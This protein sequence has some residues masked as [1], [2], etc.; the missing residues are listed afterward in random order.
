MSEVRNPGA[1]VESLRVL[2]S[3][4]PHRRRRL[5]TLLIGVTA[6]IGA[7][8][9]PSAQALD[10][11]QVQAEEGIAPGVMYRT[12]TGPGPLAA[13]TATVDPSA[14]VRFATVLSGARV[15]GGLEPVSA[16]CRRAG[17]VAC[18]N[19]NFPVCPKCQQPFG[20]VVRDR[21]IS[22][23]P[24]D[25][26]NQI[27][28]IDGRLT[29]DPWAWSARLEKVGLPG[30]PPRV[31]VAGINVPV[32]EDGIV[33]YTPEFAPSTSA[34]AGTYEVLLRAPAPLQTGPD[35][36]QPAEF[37]RAQAAGNAPIP[38]DGVVLS[39]RGRGA[40]ALWS[41]IEGDKSPGLVELVT[42][43]PAGIEQSFAGHP[44]LL[45][46]GRRLAMDQRDGKVVNRHPRTLLGWNDS[47]AVWVVVVDGRQSHSRGMTLAE[48]TDHMLALGATDAVNLDGGGS[49]TMVTR[50]GDGWCARN[51]PSDG[52]ERRVPV[53][54]AIVATSAPAA[55]A[56]PAPTPPTT[57][58]PPPVSVTV[59]PT[60]VP[61][62]VP[63]PV[64]ATATEDAV[65]AAIAAPPTTLAA[66]P[67]APV[68]DLAE[69]AEPAATGRAAV[70]G[71]AE[72]ALVATPASDVASVGSSALRTVLA[73][74]AV[75]AIGI[76]ALALARVRHRVPLG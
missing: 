23:S 15:D 76:E 37:V 53:A 73:L 63:A 9:V 18:V 7:L 1:D 20:G 56:A 30:S 65:P 3:S 28:V 48:A 42:D 36:R 75:G 35:V 26:Q 59:P 45:R 22:R 12:E 68:R 69:P 11:W 71:T 61:V 70:W 47:G 25:A 72:V 66:A 39:G 10:G 41:F 43:T 62:T 38:A 6:A 49:S 29:S 21:I 57:P 46:D 67:P 8:L 17:A 33:L 34:P 52:Q 32:V 19:A 44:V 58:P 50:C 64:E 31:E 74:I 13:F 14:S 60:T 55:A 54:L 51:R 40:D 24:T 2:P 27:S 4:L 16:M 5:F